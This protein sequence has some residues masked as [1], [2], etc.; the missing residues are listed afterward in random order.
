MDESNIRIDIIDEAIKQFF[1]DELEIVITS[2]EET[3]NKK[4]WRFSLPK[5]R[6]KISCINETMK[7]VEQG[8]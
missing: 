8:S 7:N 5:K 3:D 2:I 1:K 4:N 6:V